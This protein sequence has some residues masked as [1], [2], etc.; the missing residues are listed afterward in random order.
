[1]LVSL[2]PTIQERRDF[3]RNKQ[4]ALHLY[5]TLSA[6][7]PS[8][9][10]TDYTVT[11]QRGFAE[12]PPLGLI[13]NENLVTQLLGPLVGGLYCPGKEVGEFPL[14]KLS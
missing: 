10:D 13:R 5:N 12:Q 1:M 14:F 11:G 4:T 8:Q 2:T 7:R 3:P 9:G 6:I